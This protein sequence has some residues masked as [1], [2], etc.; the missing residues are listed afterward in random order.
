MC[1]NRDLASLYDT[2]TAAV[3]AIVGGILAQDILR[4]LSANALPIQNWFYFNGLDGKKEHTLTFLLIY[5]YTF[6]MQVLEL[7]LKTK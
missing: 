7:C 5:S 1:V 3:T 2:E 4:T 6:Q